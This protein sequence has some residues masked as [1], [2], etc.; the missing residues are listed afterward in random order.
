MKNQNN[1]LIPVLIL[2]FAIIGLFSSIYL[3]NLHYKVESSNTI[4]DIN[5]TISC[6]NLAQSKYSTIGPIPIAVMGVIAYL[7]FIGLS[8]LMLFP[9]IALGIH[10]KL[11]F[12]NV[13]K[14]V[15]T[16]TSIALLFTVYLIG[17]E[18]IVK[19]FCLGC[20]VSWVATAVLWVLSFIEYHKV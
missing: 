9:K 15:L 2:V 1:K 16:L 14:C 20:L 11:T 3:T 4:C 13:V 5:S 7:A 8:L 10:S 18:L 12:Q 6:T 19:I 17:V